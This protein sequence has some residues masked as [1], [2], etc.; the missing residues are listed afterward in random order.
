MLL[1]GG[2]FMRRNMDLFG[3]KHIYRNFII[4]V[5]FAFV[6]ILTIIFAIMN[7]GNERL[8]HEQALSEARTIFKSIVI[9]RKWNFSYNGVYV[10]KKEGVASNPYLK[11]P[12]ITAVDGR[13]F[14][15]KKPTPMTR[16]LSVLAEKE[17]LFKFH[18]TSLRLLNPDNK[19]NMP[20]A[21]ERRALALFEHGEKEVYQNVT[22]NNKTYFRYMAPLYIEKP[23]LQCHPD[24]YKLGDVRG[25]ISVMFEIQDLL[26]LQKKNTMIIISFALVSFLITLGIIQF[27]T[28]RLSNKSAE[29]RKR[30]EELAI[31]D[32]L[33]GL[34]N[35]RY[36][37]SRFR[38]EF[39]RS[40]RL[41]KDLCCLLID[42]DNFKRLNDEFGHLFGDE[43][44]KEVAVT[45]RSSMRSYDFVG[46]YG[47]EEFLIILPDTDFN[48]TIHYAERIRLLVKERL[49]GSVLNT[50]KIP[51]TISLGIASMHE[52]DS[53]VESII[54]RADE[55]LYK[56]KQTGKDRISWV[57]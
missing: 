8:I 9:M 46:R 31:T 17:G 2:T 40:K 45:I 53:S 42:I 32:D 7:Y 11:N 36:I 56:A 22:V 1:S 20:D 15:V 28:N 10:E 12:D 48:E 49:A 39:E 5:S 41:G 30:I 52:R 24:G 35:R 51:V 47:G 34:F 26:K 3:E 57:S 54:K 16:E 37:L 44:L 21:F 27:F 55:G 50:V 29:C 25:G 18:I 38:E 43:V 13:I 6:L 14:T 23:C 19:A 33:T 4:T